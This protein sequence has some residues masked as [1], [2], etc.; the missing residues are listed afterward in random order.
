MCSDVERSRHHRI[1][2]GHQ[3]E[4]KKP[5]GWRLKGVVL[6]PREIYP[7][8]R[9]PDWVAWARG[10]DGLRE[11]GKGEMPEEALLDLSYKLEKLRGDANG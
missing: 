3:V 11:E 1:G 5:D 9:S 8:I 4:A 10:P 2:F 7:T 6:G